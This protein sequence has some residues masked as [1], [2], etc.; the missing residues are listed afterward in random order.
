MT[1]S[2]VVQKQLD[3]NG[4]EKTQCRF[5]HFLTTIKQWPHSIFPILFIENRWCMNNKSYSFMWDVD[6]D[7]YAKFYGNFINLP[8]HVGHSW[9]NY[10][11]GC[12]YPRYKF[13]SGFV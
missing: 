13:N 7:L 9:E 2:I 3:P 6:T 8:L 10:I 12:N 11:S 5:K 4:L 1:M